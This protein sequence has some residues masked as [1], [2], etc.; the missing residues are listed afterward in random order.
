MASSKK[1]LIF[2]KGRQKERDMLCQP[3]LWLRHLWSTLFRAIYPA[4]LELLLCPLCT[5][6][7]G[8]C[9]TQT[10][11]SYS[12]KSWNQLQGLNY[13][14][15][16]GWNR[17]N[18]FNLPQVTNKCWTLLYWAQGWRKRY[19]QICVLELLWGRGLIQEGECIG[20]GADS[21]WPLITGFLNSFI[22]DRLG[23]G[24]HKSKRVRK[25]QMSKKFLAFT[26]LMPHISDP[27]CVH[28]APDVNRADCGSLHK[29]SEGSC[30]KTPL[31]PL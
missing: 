8:Q 23:C 4:P 17:K 9:S 15:S 27:T 1:E 3:L 26:R 5:R 11:Q 19:H 14:R 28:F 13:T 18:L 24:H 31:G 6:S 2:H 21:R 12:R 7:W 20:V 25:P 30:T 29:E 10:T 16:K 22:N